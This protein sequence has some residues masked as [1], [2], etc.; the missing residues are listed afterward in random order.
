MADDAL[1][2]AKQ[3]RTLV[4]SAHKE[5]P[6]TDRSAWEAVHEEVYCEAKGLLPRLAVHIERLTAERDAALA[7]EAVLREALEKIR[8]P[9]RDWDMRDNV[10]IAADARMDI[11]ANLRAK[12]AENV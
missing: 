8:G 6:G 11:R 7:R 1:R 2:D 10:E 12:G 4:E 5:Y 9:R 3:A